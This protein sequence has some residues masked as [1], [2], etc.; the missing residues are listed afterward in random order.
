MAIQMQQLVTNWEGLFKMMGGALV[1]EKCFWYLIDQ[2][3]ADGKFHY[4]PPGTTSA[5]LQVWDSHGKLNTI[6]HLAVT[7]ACWTLGVRLAPDDIST[8]EFQYLKN[9]VT[10]W[11]A[12]MEQAHQTHN[13]TFSV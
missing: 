5:T 4:Q 7:E 1:P 3:W 8:K 12:K 13:D 10:E 2:V 6:P 9:T 11:K